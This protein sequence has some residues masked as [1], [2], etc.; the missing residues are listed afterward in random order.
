M[1]KIDALAP[2]L[3]RERGPSAS[4]AFSKIWSYLNFLH[5]PCH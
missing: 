5:M 2:A 4:G 3:L 1:D